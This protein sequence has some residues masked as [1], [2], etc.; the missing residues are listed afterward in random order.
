MIGKFAR[1]RRERIV[2]STDHR[3]DELP[4]FTPVLR[5]YCKNIVDAKCATVLSLV[6][7]DGRH[8]WQAG[9]LERSYDR[10]EFARL[11]RDQKCISALFKLP[12]RKIFF[13]QMRLLFFHNY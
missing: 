7:R 13:D 2:G 4:G 3:D 6:G 8:E 5:W 9:V 10:S 12:S 1:N 11:D